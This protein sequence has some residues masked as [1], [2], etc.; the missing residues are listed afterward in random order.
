MKKIRIM[1][2][3]LGNICRSP[4]AH[5]ILEKIISDMNLTNIEVESSGTSGFH[6]GEKPDPRMTGV[7]ASHGVIL[8]HLRSQQFKQDD[9]ND[10]DLILPMDRDNQEHIKS[11][12]T[13]K[14]QLKKIVL[15]RDFDP[16]GKGLEVPDPYYGGPSGFEK[17]YNIADRTCKSLVQSLIRDES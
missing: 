4:L 16:E 17:V 7:A 1:L 14:S 8:D 15:F 13:K 3:C 10:F 9:L 6:N 5:G 11:M 2:V 12:I